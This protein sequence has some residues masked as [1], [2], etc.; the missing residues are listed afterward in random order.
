MQGE[1]RRT[2]RV[3]GH[4]ATVEDAGGS[5]VLDELSN[6]S[7]KKSFCFERTCVEQGY[8]KKSGWDGEA[9]KMTASQEECSEGSQRCNQGEERGGVYRHAQLLGSSGA[10]ET[11]GSPPRMRVRPPAASSPVSQCVRWTWEGVSE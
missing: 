8:G 5:E 3:R 1:E 7:H 6:C 11:S 2:S 10:A 4:I 9:M